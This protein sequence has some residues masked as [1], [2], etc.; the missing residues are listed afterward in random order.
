MKSYKLQ[1]LLTILWLIFPM[2]VE[3]GEI[4]IQSGKVQ[5][6]RDNQGNT[7]IDTGKIKVNSSPNIF[8]SRRNVG[9]V[10]RHKQVN[11][12]KRNCG[13]S[14]NRVVSQQIINARGS[15]QRTT[16]TNFLSVSCR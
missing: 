12:L 8:R 11:T 15:N 1:L 13:K 14:T 10:I 16:Q 2:V 9:S 6:N 5:I 7:T 3:A 4:N